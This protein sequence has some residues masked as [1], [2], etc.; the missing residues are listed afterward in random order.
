MRCR[1]H[2][3]VAAPHEPGSGGDQVKGQGDEVGEDSQQVYQV[4]AALDEP[5]NK[6]AAS[7][8][9]RFPFMAQLAFGHFQ[10]QLTQKTIKSTDSIQNFY[11]SCICMIW[12]KVKAFLIPNCANDV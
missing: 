4:H 10:Y 6:M 1:I 7:P 2:H 8:P 12:I 11:Q 9:N 3:Y 5:E